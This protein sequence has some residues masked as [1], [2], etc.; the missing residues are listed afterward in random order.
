VDSP[1]LN[2]VAGFP[3]GD[4]GP[5]LILN[6]HIDTVTAGDEQRWMH[7]PFGAEVVEDRLYGRGATDMKGGLTAILGAVRAIRQAGIRLKGSVQVQSVIGE[8][9]GGLAPRRSSEAT[10]RRGDHLRADA[11]L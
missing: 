8:E 2:V 4:D 11:R 7:A 6:G 10:R 5:T 1:R 9:D 3:G